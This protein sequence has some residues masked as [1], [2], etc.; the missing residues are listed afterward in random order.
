M[1]SGH[2]LRLVIWYTYVVSKLMKRTALA[3]VVVA[4]LAVA[5]LLR[6]NCIS[7]FESQWQKVSTQPASAPAPV[8][9]LH[10][11]WD[12][13]WTT[14]SGDESG[15]LRAVI[16]RLDDGR[17]QA[18]FQAIYMQVIPFNQNVTLTVDDPSAK[19]WHFKGEQDLG[20][21][22]GG[23]YYYDGTSDG[24]KFQSTYTSEHYV[25]T[26]TMKRVS[27]TTQ[28]TSQPATKPAGQ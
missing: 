10:G 1:G 8:E 13:R 24:E 15:K 14:D 9:N 19:V 7:N 4:V 12:G 27:T 3:T 22:A 5:A 26:F 16:Q 23:V 20:W 2:S 18:Q 6:M 11:V 21:M 28:P 17:Y 25:G